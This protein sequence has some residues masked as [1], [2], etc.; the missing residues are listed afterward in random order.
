[1]VLDD[2]AFSEDS[3][4]QITDWLAHAP[5]DVLAK[6][7]GVSEDALAQLPTKE[8]YIFSAVVPASFQQDSMVSRPGAAELCVSHDG[9]RCAAPARRF[10][11]HHQYKAIPAFKTADCRRTACSTP[12]TCLTADHGAS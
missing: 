10:R 8:K 12:C 5:K 7:F 3:T 11:A 6:N 1:M 2:G 9:S 4:V